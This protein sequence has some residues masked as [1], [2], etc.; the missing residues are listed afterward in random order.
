MSPFTMSSEHRASPRLRNIV[1]KLLIRV[2]L[3]FMPCE[4]LLG[5]ISVW[6]T[7][8]HMPFDMLGIVIYFSH[9]VWPEDSVIAKLVPRPLFQLQNPVCHPTHHK[10]KDFDELTP[11]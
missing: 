7:I 1:F 5:L 10:P 2:H 4:K 3:G 11:P 8:S 6:D 9:F